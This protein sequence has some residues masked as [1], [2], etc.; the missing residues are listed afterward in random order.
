MFS[1]EFTI[2]DGC[3]VKDTSSSNDRIL[4]ILDLGDD[5]HRTFEIQRRKG[6]G[7]Q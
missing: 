5:D 7:K 2:K 4:K 1:L 6:G 3:K